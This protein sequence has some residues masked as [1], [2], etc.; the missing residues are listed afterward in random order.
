M[1]IGEPGEEQAAVS[2]WEAYDVGEEEWSAE[3]LARRMEVE[4]P[5]FGSGGVPSA[6]EP[7][8]TVYRVI[9]PLGGV[10]LASERELPYA[11]RINWLLRCPVADFPVD[12]PMDMQ[13]DLWKNLL[14]ARQQ[15]H[16]KKSRESFA[17]VE[18]LTTGVPLALQAG[19]SPL[20]PSFAQA[21]P[22][23]PPLQRPFWTEADVEMAKTVTSE[24]DMGSLG[25]LGA[26]WGF[27]WRLAL[28]G[29]LE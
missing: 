17:A 23:T 21:V 10:C 29:T 6:V 22:S 25:D 19:P 16:M 7:D 11:N 2:G 15:L 28:R 12:M 14:L 3:A 8:T 1:D 18:E 24:G 26:G 5:G 4:E 13:P 27:R 20:T 9:G